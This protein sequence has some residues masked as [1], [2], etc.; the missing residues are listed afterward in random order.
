MEKISFYRRPFFQLM[1]EIHLAEE[2]FIVTASVSFRQIERIN[3]ACNP[4]AIKT[5]VYGMFGDDGS[6]EQMQAL[7][8]KTYHNDG[9]HA[10]FVLLKR[11]RK[12][13]IYIGSS[14][15]TWTSTYGDT[16]EMNVRIELSQRLP[17]KLSEFIR[18]ITQCQ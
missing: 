16:Q 12:Y 1:R 14:N 13:I 9:L 11:S 3:N 18:E 17:N 15:L 5:I 8:W 2:V 4:V 10:K 6:A 7:G